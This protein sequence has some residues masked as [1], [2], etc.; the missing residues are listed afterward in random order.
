MS[1]A[2]VATG[3]RARRAA[4]RGA[5]RREHGWAA[6]NE[7]AAE[8]RPGPRAARTRAG[9]TNQARNE[10]AEEWWSA[11]GS[12]APGAG[13]GGLSEADVDRLESLRTFLH[14][15]FHSLALFERAKAAHL[16]GSVVHEDVRTT[17]G[18]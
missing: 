7:M 16:D 14:L 17:V 13:S 11:G 8:S 10:I 9:A 5:I 4:I 12:P 18:L 2:T 1:V 15:E 3:P 6:A